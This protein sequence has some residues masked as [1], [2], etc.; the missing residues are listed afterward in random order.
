MVGLIGKFDFLRVDGAVR[1]MV[2]GFTP[3]MDGDFHVYVKEVA[4]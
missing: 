2:D 3:F 4:H 1:G